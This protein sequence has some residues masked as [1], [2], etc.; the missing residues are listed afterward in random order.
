MDVDRVLRSAI[1]ERRIVTFMLHGYHRR[2]EPHDYGIIGGIPKLFFYQVGG[3]S[4]S[5]PPVGWRWAVIAEIEDLT[6]LDDTFEGSR[7][8][9]SDRH[10]EW[11]VLFATVS[12]RMTGGRV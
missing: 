10:I 8:T 7:R 6:I 2:A 12:G 3:R 9:V 5:G 1:R 4:R 11:D